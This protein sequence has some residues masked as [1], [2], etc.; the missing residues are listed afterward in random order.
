MNQRDL[1][2]E[3]RRIVGQQYVLSEKEDV[4][5]Y[6]QH[7]SIFQVMPEIVVLPASVEEVSAVVLAARQAN[8]PIVPRGSGTG[9]AGGAVPAGSGIIPSLAPLDRNFKIDLA[10]RL[11]IVEACVIH[12]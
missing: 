7:G 11:A 3:L 2:L 9:L 8:V 10:N 5:V 4:I 6:E 12:L 1:I